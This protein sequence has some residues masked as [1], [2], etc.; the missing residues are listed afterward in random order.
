MDN[1][2]WEGRNIGRLVAIEIVREIDE[3]KQSYHED[4]FE[5]INYTLSYLEDNF[6]ENTNVNKLNGKMIADRIINQI[7]QKINGISEDKSDSYEIFQYVIEYLINDIGL[8]VEETE[9]ENYDWPDLRHQVN[10]N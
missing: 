9:K 10:H 5:V 3:L 4:N 7:I 2:E 8:I 1:L 6:G